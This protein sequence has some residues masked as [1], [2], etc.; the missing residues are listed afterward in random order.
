MAS[1]IK[2]DMP[3]FSLALKNAT[4]KALDEAGFAIVEE[5]V[6]TAPKKETTYVKQVQYIQSQR[7]VIA[8]APYSAI[9]EYGSR[10]HKI[11]PT[12]GKKALH[13]KNKN[14]DWV[15]AKIVRHPG[16]K[17]LG[18][19]RKAALKVQRQVGG[20]FI[21]NFKKELKNNV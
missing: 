5:V 9:L 1:K 6:Q 11:E 16:T 18:I 15:F 17:P 8:A 4:E 21:N 3:D 2:F 13:F 14:G 12:A 19:M 20:M 10:P 7:Q